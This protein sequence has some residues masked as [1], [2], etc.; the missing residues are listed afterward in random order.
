MTSAKSNQPVP[1]DA[2]AVE[3]AALTAGFRQLRWGKAAI[4]QLLTI[5]LSSPQLRVGLGQLV[6]AELTHRRD[7]NLSRRLDAAHLP[8][9]QASLSGVEHRAERGISDDTLADWS[10]AAWVG[11]GENLVFA[12]ASGSGSSWLA[13]AVAV[14]TIV[15]GRSLRCF[16][17]PQLLHEWL[18][19]ES[20]SAT[21]RDRAALLAFQ[22]ALLKPHVL[23]INDWGL[24][25]IDDAD[26]VALR[27]ALIPR[28]KARRSVLIASS[29][30]TAAW[31]GW[32]G[33]SD[34][35]DSLARK[36]L[37]RAHVVSTNPQPAA[38]PP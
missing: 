14:A 21:Q 9:S 38:P 8:W 12:G 15:H 18:A 35:G 5:G 31:C 17:V 28:L 2:S 32:L 11:R 16:D 1:A 10:R 37:E 19:A 30:P 34:P 33:N 3:L 4:A 23:M 27:H 25:P 26:V 7:V 29:I 6:D 24:E 20:E 13:S 36:V 22:A